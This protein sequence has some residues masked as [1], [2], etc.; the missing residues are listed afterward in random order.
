MPPSLSPI[1]NSPYPIASHPPQLNPREMP[2][3]FHCSCHSVRCATFKAF[4]G[5]KNASEVSPTSS[6]LY[7]VYPVHPPCTCTYHHRFHML[8]SSCNFAV[9][10]VCIFPLH[11]SLCSSPLASLFRFVMHHIVTILMSVQLLGE[12][13]SFV[14]KRSDRSLRSERSGQCPICYSIRWDF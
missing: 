7:C 4:I 12:F 1:P 2:L 11:S 8:S 3:E 14:R 6:Y 13:R 10:H 5:L 9:V